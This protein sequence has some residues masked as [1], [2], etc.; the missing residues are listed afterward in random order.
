MRCV[1]YT[2]RKERASGSLPEDRGFKSYLGNQKMNGSKITAI[3]Y[4]LPKK[5]ENNKTLKRFNPKLD[6]NRIKEKTGINNRYISAE[7]ETVI[8]LSIKCSN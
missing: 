2:D 5:K 7:K 4:Y 3:E 8:D 6:I 1:N